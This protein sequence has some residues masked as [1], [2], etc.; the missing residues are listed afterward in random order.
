MNRDGFLSFPKTV[1]KDIGT[2]LSRK[3]IQNLL[4]H[5]K[6]TR[7]DSFTSPS[8]REIKRTA[9]AT[10]NQFF[11]FFFAICVFFHEY[12]RFTGQQGKGRASI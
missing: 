7:T 6:Q 8:K 12:L 4:D 9:E 5:V 3:Y 11:F 1:G 10:S 2:N